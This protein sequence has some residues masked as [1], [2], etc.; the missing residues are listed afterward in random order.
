MKAL[1]GEYVRLKYG[2]DGKVGFLTKIYN[3]GGQYNLFDLDYSNNTINLINLFIE[4]LSGR[5]IYHFRAVSK[6]TD[7]K[8]IIYLTL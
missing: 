1:V 6:F 5:K 2:I 3:S 7:V 4:L 8:K